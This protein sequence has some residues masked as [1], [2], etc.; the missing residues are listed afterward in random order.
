[1]AIVSALLRA[2]RSRRWLATRTGIPY[3]TLRRKLQAHADLSVTDLA[4]IAE[5]LEVSP[6][7]L[8]PDTRITGKADG[9]ER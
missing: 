7:S 8:L 9:Q 3:S 5:A 2:N 1:M 6:A 4:R